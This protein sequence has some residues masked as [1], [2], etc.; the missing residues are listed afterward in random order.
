MMESEDST[1]TTAN[2]NDSTRQ[3]AGRHR[4]QPNSNDDDSTGQ[5]GAQR[6]EP[7]TTGAMTAATIFIVDG[8]PGA[9]RSE[10]IAIQIHGAQTPT[11]Q[12][13]EPPLGVPRSCL[14]GIHEVSKE[15]EGV[16]P[17]RRRTRT[18]QPRA[19]RY[20]VDGVPEGCVCGGHSRLPEVAHRPGWLCTHK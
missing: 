8:Q 15:V 12:D 1:T 14:G 5:P 10:L 6:S 3:V 7:T 11:K 20:R 19:R 16:L 17:V 13:T 18:A 4:A 2:D 9:T